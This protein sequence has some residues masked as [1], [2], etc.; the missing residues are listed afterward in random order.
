TAM[1]WLTLFGSAATTCLFFLFLISLESFRDLAWAGF[2]AGVSPLASRFWR[3]ASFLFSLRLSLWDLRLAAIGSPPML[4]SLLVKTVMGELHPAAEPSPVVA[5]AP[6]GVD[7]A[8]G[9]GF[10]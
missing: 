4:T 10:S 6:A 1:L 9:T 3:L 7:F 5:W 8:V 2:V